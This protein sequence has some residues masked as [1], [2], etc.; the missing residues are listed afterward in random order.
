MSRSPFSGCGIVGGVVFGGTVDEVFAPET[1]CRMTDSMA[2]RGP[3][4]RGIWA[5]ARCW[6]GHRRLAILDLDARGAQP[7]I[8]GRRVLSY[9]GE[10]YNYQPLRRELE[11]R[12]HR[13]ETKTDTEVL[14]AALEEWG[15][16]ALPRLQGMFAFALWDQERGELLLARDPLG[17]KPLYLHRSTS[18]LTFASEVQALLRSPTVDAEIDDDFLARTIACGFYFATHAHGTLVRGVEQCPPGTLMRLSAEGRVQST[19]YWTVE[20]QDEPTAEAVPQ[21]REH[22]VASVRRHLIADVP[23]ASFLSGGLDSSIVTVLAAREHGESLYCQTLGDPH[24]PSETNED[25]RQACSLVGL[26]SPR[27]HHELVSPDFGSLRLEDIDR[28][29]DVSCIV[30]DHRSLAIA[31]NFA[32]VHARG[33]RAVLV[34]QGADELMGGYWG[35]NAFHRILAD[36]ADDGSPRLEARLGALFGAPL[37]ALRGALVPRIADDADDHVGALLERLRPGDPGVRS[38]SRDFLLSTVLRGIL[39]LED[40][41]GMQSSVE[42]RVPF[43]DAELLSW[44]LGRPLDLHLDL[45]G[46]SGKTLLKRAFADLLPAAIIE[47]PK[48]PLPPVGTTAL[49]TSLRRIYREGFRQILS[50]ELVRRVFRREALARVE[51]P[52]NPQ[53]LWQIIALWR[54]GECLQRAARDVASPP[55]AVACP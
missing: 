26:L 12:G 47:R 5:D 45:E 39:K 15:D 25:A 17:I 18:A 29:C 33:L 34:G 40:Y 42:A 44:T 50:S 43:L 38:R 24:D 30:D 36:H 21:L 19:R 23:V 1:M 41:L 52:R 14:L 7:M 53:Q 31:H 28:V 22:L 10:I 37:H 35:R 11:S 20:L 4:G 54:T 27:P 32:R 6:L 51:V 8:R 2:H 48:Q 13:F 46:G 55:R 49:L 9:N 3:S 16:S